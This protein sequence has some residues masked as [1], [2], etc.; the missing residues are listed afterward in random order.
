MSWMAPTHARPIVVRSAYC[1]LGRI[2]EVA[3]QPSA[4]QPVYRADAAPHD[5]TEPRF[6]GGRIET[7]NESLRGQ[8]VTLA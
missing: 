4:V 2:S 8:G 7:L 6:V 3:L 5:F 1:I